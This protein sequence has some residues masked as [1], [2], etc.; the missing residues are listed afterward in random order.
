MSHL[1]NGQMEGGNLRDDAGMALHMEWKKEA[2][3]AGLLGKLFG[4]GDK[5]PTN[6]AGLTIALI[7][8]FVFTSCFFDIKPGAV[9]VLEKVV[10]V[11]TLV[12]GYLFGRGRGD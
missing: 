11:V 12:L 1:G 6:I 10:P 5:A 2:L 9:S 3:N 8:V 7:F 4:A